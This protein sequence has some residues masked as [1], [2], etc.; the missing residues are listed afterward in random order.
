MIGLYE[1]TAT[2]GRDDIVV[3]ILQ[4]GLKLRHVK[5]Y[6]HETVVT[7]GIALNPF[8]IIADTCIVRSSWQRGHAADN[9]CCIPATRDVADGKLI[10]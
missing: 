8:S 10:G 1:Q 6:C 7:E 2:I 3:E 4:Y 9:F 5:Q